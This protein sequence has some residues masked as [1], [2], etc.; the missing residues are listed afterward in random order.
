M[1]RKMEKHQKLQRLYLAQ[2]L[3]IRAHV[4]ENNQYMFFTLVCQILSCSKR[5]TWCNNALNTNETKKKHVNYNMY[6]LKLMVSQFQLGFETMV[7]KNKYPELQ[8]G[9]N[10]KIQ[11]QSISYLRWIVGQVK[12][13]T[14]I[15]HRPIFFK[16]LFEKSSSLHVDL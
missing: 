8:N 6:I 10:H 2:G 13:Q 12:K 9:N 4:G 11:W 5:N 3:S 15:L 1:G 7:S 14:Y 16:V